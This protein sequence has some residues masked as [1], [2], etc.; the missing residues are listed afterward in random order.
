MTIILFHNTIS[1]LLNL[2]KVFN[3]LYT[4]IPISCA[5]R[6]SLCYNDSDLI[7]AL[8]PYR[9][10]RSPPAYH[11][12]LASCLLLCRLLVRIDHL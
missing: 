11:H 7:I 4:D 10:L 5:C 12:Y 1:Y 3:Y 8:S 2:S 6:P 9:V